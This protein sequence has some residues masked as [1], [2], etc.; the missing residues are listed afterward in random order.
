MY[1]TVL[2]IGDIIARRN[3][4]VFKTKGLIA[5]KAGLSLGLVTPLTPD[6]PVKLKK[7]RDA[8]RDVL[9]ELV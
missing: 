8:A 4:P 1:D 2:K 7:L 3:L 6:D 5:I 9:Q